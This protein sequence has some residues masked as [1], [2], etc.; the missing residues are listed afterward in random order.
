MYQKGFNNLLV[1]AILTQGQ[2]KIENYFFG[3]CFRGFPK[4]SWILN[5]ENHSHLMI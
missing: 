5:I 1:V 4:D 3:I 2:V